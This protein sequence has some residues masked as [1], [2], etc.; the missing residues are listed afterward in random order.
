MALPD[1]LLIWLAVV[2]AA[3]EVTLA[4]LA[5]VIAG[6]AIFGRRAIVESAKRE[7]R[8]SAESEVNERLRE[9]N[10]REMILRAVQKEGNILYNDLQIADQ[11]PKSE[12]EERND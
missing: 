6:F 3:V 9:S 2:L 12:S 11:N 10:L 8:R 5:I 4:V 7:A 1:S